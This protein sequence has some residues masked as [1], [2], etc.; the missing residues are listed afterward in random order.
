MNERPNMFAQSDTPISIHERV[1]LPDEQLRAL[2]PSVF[3]SQPMPG[4]TQTVRPPLALTRPTTGNNKPARMPITATT[5]NLFHYGESHC[6]LGV[7]AHAGWTAQRTPSHAAESARRC[8]CVAFDNGP[9][10]NREAVD[11]LQKAW[12]GSDFLAPIRCPSGS[13]ISPGLLPRP[14]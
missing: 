9:S 3:A 7:G 11:S 5:A 10:T 1:E 2:A 4:V 8:P 14:H 6:R 13:R 12:L